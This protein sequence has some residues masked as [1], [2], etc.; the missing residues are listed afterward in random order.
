MSF[1]YFFYLTSVYWA[2]GKYLLGD[3]DEPSTSAGSGACWQCSEESHTE[4]TCSFSLHFFL[5]LWASWYL[6][7]RVFVLLY[8]VK[9]SKCKIY[10]KCQIFELLFKSQ[11]LYYYINYNLCIYI[12][13]P[14]LNNKVYFSLTIWPLFVNRYSSQGLD[15]LKNYF[16]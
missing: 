8:F 16:I 3:P 12:Y 2:S 5:I 15:L 7:C 11:V 13:L 4:P 9:L 10:N 1:Y 14:N 6:P